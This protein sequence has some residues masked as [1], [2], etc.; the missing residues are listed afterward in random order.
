M[1]RRDR[2]ELISD[3]EDALDD[4]DFEISYDISSYYE[5]GVTTFDIE[6]DVEDFDEDQTPDDWDEDV[7]GAIESVIED[8]GGW[9]S[10]DGSTISLSIEG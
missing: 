8:W 1:N 5:D 2:E 7:E 9:Y 6:I 4:L 3:I 10:W